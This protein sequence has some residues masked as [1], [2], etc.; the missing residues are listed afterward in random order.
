MET[1][2]VLLNNGLTF[3]AIATG[4][5]LVVVGGFL[6]KL[7]VDLSKLTKNVDETTSV[8]RN[9][10]RPTLRELNE[11]LHTLNDFM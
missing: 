3:L 10:L 7:I 2:Q 9:E 6:V 8:V 4:I 5:M 11:S 1:S